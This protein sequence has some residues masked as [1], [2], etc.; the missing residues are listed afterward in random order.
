MCAELDNAR[1]ARARL[2]RGIH[3]LDVSASHRLL[4]GIEA[5]DGLARDRRA[6]AILSVGLVPGVTNLLARYCV[7]RETTRQVRGGV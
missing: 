1:V 6:T 4:T 7:E 3:Y 2:E 5:S